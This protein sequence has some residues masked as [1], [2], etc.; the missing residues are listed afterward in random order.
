MDHLA[1][2]RKRSQGQE[3]FPVINAKIAKK[4]M[5]LAEV[6]VTLQEV[7]Q[8]RWGLTVPVMP[9]PALVVLPVLPLAMCA[10]HSGVVRLTMQ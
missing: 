9:D 8:V 5:G 6:K 2:A 3:I 7:A 10:V 1:V 4:V